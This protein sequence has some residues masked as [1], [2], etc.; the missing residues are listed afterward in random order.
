TLR[1]NNVWVAQDYEVKTINTKRG[2]VIVGA[3]PYPVRARLMQHI[4]GKGMSIRDVD[5]QLESELVRVLQGLAEEADTLDPDNSTPRILTGH[6]TVRGAILG[7]ERSVMLGRDVQVSPSL[8]ADSRWDYVAL[9]HIHKH[10]NL[11]AGQENMPPVVYSGS[12]ECIDF[13]EEHDNKGYCWLELQRNDV[14]WK[15]HP[16]NARRMKT[17]RYDCKKDRL[18]TQTIVRDIKKESLK[19]AIVRLIIDLTPETD[20][21]LNDG[22]I[23]DALKTA[24]VFHIA[25]IRREVERA[26]RARLGGSP[27]GLTHEELLERY[28]ISKDVDEIRRDELL[29]AAR[30]IIRGEE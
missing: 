4:S 24:G 9:G 30:V 14:T 5:D 23:R 29:E 25:S 18:P 21:V 17:L 15:H 28:F 12:L 2:D 22:K 20:A 26:D 6:F 8:L 19:G 27:E 1:V 10:Q 11:T 13:G 7:S 3:A 16:V